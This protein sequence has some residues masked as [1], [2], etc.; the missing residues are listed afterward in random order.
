MDCAESAKA[1]I[2][3]LIQAQA[4]RDTQQLKSAMI[5]PMGASSTD[6][7]EAVI[8]L[9]RS[10]A[11]RTDLRSLLSGVAESLRRIVR[12]DHLG[13][14]LHDANG[15]AMQGYI[16]NEPGNPVM[17]SLRLPVDED[18][19]GWVWQNQQ[20]LVISDL[21]SET[22]W[23]EGVRIARELG[24][25]T[26]ILVP[27]SAGDNRFGAFGFCSVAPLAP[28]PAEIA[29]L[30]RVASEFAVAVESFLARQ[31]AVRERD[32][33]RTLFDI[34]DSLVSKLNQDDLFSAI[35]GQLSKIIRHDY[36]ML[37]LC[38]DNGGLDVYALHSTGP[39]LWEELKGPFN[40]E[41]MPA[42]EVLATGKPVVAGGIDIDRYPNPNFRRFLALGFKSICSVPLITR[43]RAFGTLALSRHDR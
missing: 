32:R 28:T 7:Y 29:F 17:T 22:R 20:P 36:A 16:L 10:I 33:L 24:I 18:P 40:P 9:S 4:L 8:A 6:I 3:R 30:E 42:A 27:L 25:S 5:C 43:D 15:N 13:L 2:G 35:S 19:A 39:Q 1:E 12:F 41:G 14:I 37:T 38:N 31:A 11:G 34:T 26:L 21:G 23:P